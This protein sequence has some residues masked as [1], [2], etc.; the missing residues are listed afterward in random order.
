MAHDL[1]LPLLGAGILGAVICTAADA[2]VLPDPTR[3]PAAL[4]A[5]VDG[6]GGGEAVRLVLQSVL[7][8]P[9][10]KAAVISGK[11]VAPGGR[12]EGLTLVRL[13]ETEATLAG[14]RGSVRLR[15]YPGVEKLAG[16]PPGHTD[17]RSGRQ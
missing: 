1:R 16:Q 9:E 5:P 6:Q 7:L 3:P 11:V 13:T 14:P 12:I 4:H 15:L 8:S 17:L 2:E 10:R